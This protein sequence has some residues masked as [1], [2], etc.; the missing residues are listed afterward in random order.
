MGLLWIDGFDTYGPAGTNGSNLA[1]LFNTEGYQVYPNL[2]FSSLNGIDS[3]T[4]SGQ[5]FS[6]KQAS[7]YYTLA[8]K[9][10][11]T[12][13]NEIITGFALKYDTMSTNSTFLRFDFI[14]LDGTHH[15][16]MS[17]FVNSAGQIVLGQ[18]NNRYTPAS[19][20]AVAASPNNT[21]FPNIWYY[22]EVKYVLGSP[23]YVEVHVDGTTVLTFTGNT[24]LNDQATPSSGYVAPATMI[25]CVLLNLTG[26]SANNM[27]VDDW[28][29]LDGTTPG[30]RDFIGD[31]VVVTQLPASDAG[32]NAMTPSA[33]GSHYPLLAD[34]G[35]DATY[36]SATTGGEQELFGLSA[37]PTNI[38]TV[39]AVQIHAR[40]QRD[41]DSIFNMQL[42]AKG[43][44]IYSTTAIPIGSTF[45][46]YDLVLENSPDY[47]LWTVALA[48]ALEIGFESAV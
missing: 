14:E 15:G 20:N 2:N 16:Q 22:V 19:F 31:H 46:G 41:G 30:L 43:T 1:A 26:P 12:P 7:S 10:L 34:P 45:C 40:A 8:T 4:R 9:V 29:L 18:S 3:S 27:W 11:N 6:L 47:M 13:T 17:I 35:S 39:V 24:G 37:L 25:N 42:Q 33:A 28:Y 48:N 44:N 5:G 23:G 38:S 32:P 21:L 36:V